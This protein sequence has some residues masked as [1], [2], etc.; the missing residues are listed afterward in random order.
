MGG[1][2]SLEVCVRHVCRLLYEASQRASGTCRVRVSTPLSGGHAGVRLKMDRI[3]DV[4]EKLIPFSIHEHAAKE[5]CDI[6]LQP[7]CH[8]AELRRPPGGVP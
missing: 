3:G 2:C 5:E 1:A 8:L 7:M 6:A 4:A